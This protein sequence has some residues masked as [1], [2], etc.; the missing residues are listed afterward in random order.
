MEPQKSNGPLIGAIIIVVI[1]V[2]G[3]I[4]LWQRTA[5]EAPLPPADDLAELEANLNEVDLESL[6]EGI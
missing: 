5:K 1:L 4:Y 6:D 2:I 3:G